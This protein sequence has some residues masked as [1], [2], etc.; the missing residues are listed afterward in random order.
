MGWPGI[1]EQPSSYLRT[2][3]SWRWPWRRIGPYIQVEIGA[4]PFQAWEALTSDG[5][6]KH[7]LQRG[8]GSLRPGDPMTITMGDASGTMIWET[9]RA[10]DAGQEFPSYLPTSN[11]ACDARRGNEPSGGGFVDRTCGAGTHPLQVFHF[12]WEGLPLPEPIE[13]RR[14][15][16]ILTAF[17]VSAFG[18]AQTLFAPSAP[19]PGRH[20]WSSQPS[21]SVPLRSLRSRVLAAPSNRPIAWKSTVGLIMRTVASMV[22]RAISG[23]AKSDLA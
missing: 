10:V 23:K 11:S 14:I 22:A 1:L 9:G 20:G 2:G 13:E 6:I 5:A 17:W 12:N 16:R 18:R 7:W 21:T 3:T 4:P 8:S 15:L 19:P